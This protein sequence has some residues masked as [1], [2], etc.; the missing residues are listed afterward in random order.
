MKRHDTVI[1]ELGTEELPPKGL[2]KLRD[3]LG[4]H[5]E[6]LLA[7]AGLPYQQL[8]TFAAPRRLAV[9]IK[10]LAI[11]QPD[12]VVE[13]RGPALTA[14]WQADGSPTQATLGFAR[15]LHVDPHDLEVLK[16]E[17]GE[18]LFYRQTLK[19][20]ESSR[21]L[22]E[23]IQQALNLLPIAKRMRWGTGSAEFVRPVKWVL[24]MADEQL[25]EAEIFGL[26]TGRETWGHRFHHPGAIS[27][28]HAAEYSER[29]AAEGYVI[30]RFEMRKQRIIEQVE[31]LAHELGGR[32]PLDEALLEEV[33]ALVEWPVALA[34][35]F[36]ARYLA[37]PAE[38]LI[39]TMQE[40][41]KYFPLM[42]EE[43]GLLPHFITVSNLES[44]QPSSIRSGNERVIRPRLAD[45]EF[46]WQQDRKQSLDSKVRQ[47]AHVTFQKDLGSVLDKTH[48]VV[49]I[50]RFIARKMGVN[51]DEAIRAAYL[52]K[53][54]LLT[55][56]VGEFPN[57]QGVMG[58]YYA[59]AEGESAEVAFAI[60]EQYYPRQSG[61]AL[62]TRG[63]GRVLALAE[64]LDTLCGI[65]SAGLIPTG[66]KDPYA[67]RR[68]AL[69]IIRILLDA[70][71]TLSLSWL[72][73]TALSRFTH[74]FDREHIK[75]SVSIFLHERLRGHCLENGF[76]HDEFE[77]VMAVFPDNLHDF[78]L[79]MEAVRSFRQ[80]DASESL[81]A[82]NKRI[83]NLLRKA[84]ETGFE[85]NGD[86]SEALLIDPAEKIMAA[87][88]KEA[89][90]ATEP[91][92]QQG[93]YGAALQRL[94]N[95]RPSVD[96]FFADIMV[97]TDDAALRNNRLNLLAML[98]GLFMNIA[99]IARLQRIEN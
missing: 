52:A 73:D 42:G 92:M 24:L 60:E 66:D 37:L 16:T 23:L 70:K 77:A 36:D 69:G 58:R 62:P 84:A 64:K 30:S 5:L 61:S 38:A 81:A 98:A 90:F 18:W 56:M 26:K 71:S 63:I 48:R 33:T 12:Q 28:S 15:G 75:A 4:L 31:S 22:P 97:M 29:L 78:M 47:L 34:G 85:P 86:Y 79:R 6:T 19:G 96:Q 14:A 13:K 2:L 11:H 88:A 39:T 53:A 57:L 95:L 40:N 83:Q 51:E 65:F 7:K 25:I 10:G 8:E 17:K 44:H 76:Q 41:Q 68:A 45:A 93:H 49:E 46:F 82:A 27:L 99:D 72:V 9:M 91:L 89:A 94:A 1:F 67:L 55:E 21:L 20:A 3:A 87:E 74:A 59:L 80:I 43:G 32:V 50:S 35:S 54:D